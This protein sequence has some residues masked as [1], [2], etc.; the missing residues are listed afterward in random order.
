M[1]HLIIYIS[2]VLLLCLALT[3]RGASPTGFQADF[4]VVDT[5]RTGGAG[6][7]LAAVVPAVIASDTA[8]GES[9]AVVPAARMSEAI[10][11]R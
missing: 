8:A 2:A 9:I 3:G 5:P 1:R 4:S 7:S 6:D 10:R 11:Q